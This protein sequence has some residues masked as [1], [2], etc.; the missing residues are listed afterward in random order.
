MT[1]PRRAPALSHPSARS[2]GQSRANGARRW[3]V[4]APRPC[5]KNRAT[6]PQFPRAWAPRVARDGPLPLRAFRGT[7]AA[8]GARRCG[9]RRR[10]SRADRE[11]G[12]AASPCDTP[13]RRLAAPSPQTPPARSSC[14][15]PCIA[16]VR[17]RRRAWREAAPSPT[18]RTR[19]PRRRS[20]TPAGGS[21]SRRVGA[22]AT[23]DGGSRSR[24]AVDHGEAGAKGSSCCGSGSR[25][26]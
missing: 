8:G 2:R 16:S 11:R 9:S 14:G 21:R 25:R 24:R 15:T 3:R 17:A 7:S 20:R 12:R 13:A 6:S 22:P 5:P 1:A 18:L 26:E 23:G 10:P 19:S 4:T